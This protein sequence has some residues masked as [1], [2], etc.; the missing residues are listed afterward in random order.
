MNDCAYLSTR[1]DLVYRHA[2]AVSNDGNS[3]VMASITGG[4]W[5]SDDSGERW[6]T[7]SMTM[8]PFYAV[9]FA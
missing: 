6:Q 7:V 9:C 8:P 5:I 2:L 1:Y 3:I 4:V